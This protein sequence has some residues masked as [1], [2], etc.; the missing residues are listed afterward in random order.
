M[1]GSLLAVLGVLALASSARAQDR[2]VPADSPRPVITVPAGTRLQTLLE[3][4][5]TRRTSRPGSPV[6]LQVAHPVVVHDTVALPAGT[7]VEGVLDHVTSARGLRAR[8][9]LHVTRL[10]YG[11]GYVLAASQSAEGVA[12]EGLGDSPNPYAS[13]VFFG[14]VA[15]AFGLLDLSAA[16]AGIHSTAFLAPDILLV[17]LAVGALFGHPELTLDEGT[18]VEIALR[19]PLTLDARRATA[20]GAS[21]LLLPRRRPTSCFVP[22][23]PPS[24]DVVIPG[25]LGTPDVVI[26]GAPGTPDVVIPGTPA[27]PPTII[28]GTPGT[29]G[30]WVPCHR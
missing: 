20:P 21:A 17:P 23:T 3:R 26:P 27:T 9:A 30:T 12:G 24:P 1:R 18:P 16:H 8:L 25:T 13:A 29:P 10:V 2:T 11:N 4:P 15:L 6:Y 7:Y 28:P 14:A 5:L 22:G 19:E